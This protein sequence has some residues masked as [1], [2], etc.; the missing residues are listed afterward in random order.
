MF[1]TLS[2]QKS[3]NALGGFT[4]NT[5]RQCSAFLYRSGFS[6]HRE[7]SGYRLWTLNSKSPFQFNYLRGLMS[8]C[9]SPSGFKCYVDDNI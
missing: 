3:Q 5:T 4:I 1:L 6:I 2:T 8:V 9:V 7:L